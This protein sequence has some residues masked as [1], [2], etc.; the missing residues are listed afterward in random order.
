MEVDVAIVGGGMVGASLALALR[1]LHLDV[2]LIEALAPDSA[3]QTSFDERTTALGNGTRR[4]FEAL[5]VWDSMR[6][7]AAAIR[8]IHVSE[9]GGFGFA[10]LVAAE[11][12]IEAFGY[13]VPNRVIG[14]VLWEALRRPAHG[15][16]RLELCMPASVR[17]AVIGAERVEL[18]VEGAEFGSRRIAAR[19]AVAA[20]GA[21][22]VLRERAGIGAA[23]EDYAQTAV[24]ASVRAER[25]HD[26]T[27][28][29]RFTT[30]GP[31]AF[32]P[33]HD[34]SY[35]V[36][37]TLAPE[38]AAEVLCLDDAV[39]LQALQQAFGWRVGR[40]EQ[41]GRR[42]SYPLA[43]TRA[44]ATVAARTVLI[45]NAS[46]SLHPVAG[47]GFN[48][49][50]RDAATLAELIGELRGGAPESAAAGADVGAA[51]F[52]ASFAARRVAD[53][54][55]VTR[56]TDGLIR[57]FGDDRPGV[58][59]ARNLG[60]LLFDLAPPAKRALS[61]LSLGFAGRTPR[62]ARGLPLR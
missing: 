59:F 16:G 57:L 53:R 39:F 12:G 7:D 56:F 29:E 55:G 43:L 25:A 45:G 17:D 35:T 58:G 47:Q 33:R 37:W 27:A 48:L 62:L 31:L 23:V 24:I 36:I 8:T 4:V 42:A 10:R 34:G 44:E 22:S 28:Y 3:A 49:G 13:V 18:R 50:L 5:K 32:L 30:D 54:G 41:V 14:R 11:Q 40:L 15:P 51:P 19:L 38:R 61:R 20:D 46:Q 2:A 52:L 9:R 26:G 1:G 60:L 21:N 6:G